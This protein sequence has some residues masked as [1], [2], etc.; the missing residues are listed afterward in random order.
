MCKVNASSGN[1]PQLDSTHDLAKLPVPQGGGLVPISL[2]M[3]GSL[4]LLVDPT[5]S[6]KGLADFGEYAKM[7]DEHVT[8]G[9]S[10]PPDAGLVHVMEGHPASTAPVLDNR[11]SAR[12]RLTPRQL[13]V[14]ELLCEGLPNKL[15]CQRLNIS[16]GTVKVH[17]GGILR[18]LGVSS[19]LQAVV[20]ARRCGLVGEAVQRISERARANGCPPADP[21]SIYTSEEFPSTANHCTVTPSHVGG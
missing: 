17:I 4:I 12:V 18:Q 15:I 1:S 13:E 7:G 21:P 10:P 9:A 14:L 16:T 2:I 20:L 3:R 8:Y 5:A 11:K 19:R 6:A